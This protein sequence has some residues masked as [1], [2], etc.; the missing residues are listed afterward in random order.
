MYYK[1][2]KQFT[3]VW[4]A[5]VLSFLL[6][7]FYSC[8]PIALYEQTKHFSSQQWKSEEKAS[9]VFELKDT[10]A[11][12]NV[13]IVLRHTQAYHFNNIWLNISIQ[14]SSGKSQIFRTNLKLANNTQWLGSEMGDVVEHRIALFSQPVALQKG[15]YQFVLQH[16]MRE[17]PLQGIL[18]AGIRVE[19]A[20]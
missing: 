11:F 8:K 13:Y 18:Q 3:G 1:P 6:T 7:G 12:Y 4:F 19:K 14:P 5:I 9:F 20:F 15:R 16:I 10:T 2:F 17:N